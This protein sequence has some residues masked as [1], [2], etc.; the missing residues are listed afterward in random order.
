MQVN[1]LKL[2]FKILIILIKNN[3]YLLYLIDKIKLS[4]I[5][6]VY[7]IKSLKFQFYYQYLQ[8]NFKIQ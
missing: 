7:Y 6:N 1:N 3:H 2:I 4:L 8:Q 5:N